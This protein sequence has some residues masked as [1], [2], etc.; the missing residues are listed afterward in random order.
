MSQGKHPLPSALRQETHRFLT[1]TE[2]FLWTELSPGFPRRHMAAAGNSR[3][4][5]GLAEPLMALSTLEKQQT[6]EPA[7]G[8][9]QTLNTTI[10]DGHGASPLAGPRGGKTRLLPGPGGPCPTS[11]SRSE[12][13]PAP[14]TQVLL[15]MPRAGS[16]KASERSVLNSEPL[17]SHSAA[18]VLFKH[19]RDT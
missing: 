9:P 5:M 3:L 11:A 2:S 10:A 7:T 16:A 17:P 8:R 1:R 14:D 4:E 13:A 12:P 15:C 18:R 6:P 19:T